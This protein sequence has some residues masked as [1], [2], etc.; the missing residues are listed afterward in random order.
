MQLDQERTRHE[1]EG[2]SG[3]E[4]VSNPVLAEMEEMEYFGK[5]SGGVV[6]VILF[7]EISVTNIFLLLSQ[8]T[9]TSLA[10]MSL[11][12]ENSSPV[13]SGYC[14][15]RGSRTAHGWIVSSSQ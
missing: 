11:Q 1:E 12:V 9:V 10:G 7:M 5:V 13:H 3:Q 6:S 8:L 2:E 15:Y 4:E 14:P